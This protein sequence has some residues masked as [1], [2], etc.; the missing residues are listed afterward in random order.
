[1]SQHSEFY[2]KTGIKLSKLSPK[3]IVYKQDNFTVR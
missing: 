3:G 2:I 1:M